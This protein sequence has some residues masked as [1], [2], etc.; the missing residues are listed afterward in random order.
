MNCSDWVLDVILGID[1]V[2]GF[3]SYA[4]SGLIYIYEAGESIIEYYGG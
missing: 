3:H 1:V 4:L 2:D